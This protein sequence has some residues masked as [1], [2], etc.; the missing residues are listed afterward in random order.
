MSIGADHHQAGTRG[1]SI[2]DRLGSFPW[3]CLPGQD[4][5]PRWTRGGFEVMGR[6]ESVLCYATGVAGWSADLTGLHED[7]AG[8]RHPIDVASRQLAVDSLAATGDSPLVLEVGCSSGYLADTV[9]EKLPF[10]RMICADYVDGGLKQLAARRPDVACLQFDLTACPLPDACVD[11]V[12]ALNVIEHIPDD[13]RAVRE[14]ARLLRP[15]GRAHLEVPAGPDL[16]DGYDRFLMHHRRY[17]GRQL[18]RLMEEAGFRVIRLTHLG[19]LPYPLFRLIKR[20]N[21]RQPAMSKD[22]LREWVKGQMRSTS[23]SLLMR[24]AMALEVRLGKFWNYPCG[25]RCVCVGE[26]V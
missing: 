11:A 20:R 19:F 23:A 18:A 22:Q 12:V 26:R 13:A 14:I 10:A 5:P 17:D 16:F 21:Q 7:A 2:G 9:G 1:V 6:S 4:T 25:I 3:P 15:G 8:S 24:L